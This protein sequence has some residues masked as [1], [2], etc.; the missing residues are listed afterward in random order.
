MRE[1]LFTVRETAQYLSITEAEV[2]ELSEKGIVPAYKVGGVYLRF[3]KE[4]LDSI[5]DKITPL[6]KED[7]TKHSFFE[8]LRDFLYYNDFYIL[9]LLIV[10]ILIFLISNYN[11]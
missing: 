8:R 11:L 5:K 3:K 1:K 4:Q 9:A 10:S 2:V 7:L 6:K